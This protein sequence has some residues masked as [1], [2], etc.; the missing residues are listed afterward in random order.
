[1]KKAIARKNIILISI[2][3]IL[4]S[5]ILIFPGTASAGTMQWT[6]ID[7]PSNANNVIVSPSEINFLAVASSG[8]L[9]ATDVAHSKVYRSPDGGISWQDISTFLINAGA[10]L[11]AWNIE[12]SPDNPGLV[13]A[14][15]STGG[16][17]RNVFVSFDGGENWQNL[18]CP[19]VNNIS[20]MDISR[21]YGSYDIAVGT[22]NGAGNGKL[23]AF[24]LS[25][26]ANWQD[27]GITG[28]VISTMFSP[29]Y[30]G[31]NTLLA[32][33]ANA[34]GTFMNLGIRDVVAN[35]TSWGSWAPLEITTSGSGT[36]PNANQIK[37]ADI[38]MPS[39]FLGQTPS[40]RRI[41]VSINDGGATGN[42]GIFRI[43]NVIP[44]RIFPA[45]GN[46]MISSIS[47]YGNN[48]SGKLLAG[49][50][51]ADASLATVNIHVC[52]N[53]AQNCPLANCL[54]WHK[55][56]K[57]PTGGGNTGNGNAQV[58]WNVDGI[59]AYCGTSSADLIAGG[60]PNGYSISQALDE[61]AFSYSIDN[62]DTWNQISLIDTSINFLS[63]VVSSYNADTLYLTSINTNAGF[64]GFDSVWRGTGYPLFQKWERIMCP[65]VTS[66]DLI[67]R[68]DFSE[69]GQI[70]AGFRSTPVIY[71]SMDNGQTWRDVIPNVNVADFAAVNIDGNPNLFV[72]SD[73]FVRR[74]EFTGTAWHW[75]QDMSTTLFSG[76]SL[77]VTST[78]VIVVGDTGGGSAYALNFGPQFMQ[79]PILPVGGNV[80]TAVDIRIANYLLIYAA[81]DD[82]SSN[83]YSYIVNTSAGWIGMSAP[84]QQYYGLT[85]LG[86][87]YGVW[88]TGGNSGVS[89][90]LNPESRGAPF[91]E[92]SNLTSGLPAGISFTREPSALKASAGINLWAIDNNNYTANTG[93]L[94][95]FYDGLAAGPVVI[96]PPEYSENLLQPPT[97]VAPENDTLIPLDFDTGSTPPIEFK[98][99]HNTEANGYDLW[100]AADNNFTNTVLL[101]SV[102]PSN[103]M[104]PS[105][106]IPAKG[107]P[108]QPGETYYWK[109]RVNRVAGTYQRAEGQWSEIMSF[110]L[111]SKYIP[112]SPLQAPVLTTPEDNSVLTEDIINFIWEPVP[113][114]T[115]YLFVLSGNPEMTDIIYDINTEA[116]SFRYTSPLEKGK[117]YYWNVKVVEPYSSESSPVFSFSL[118]GDESVLTTTLNLPDIPVWIF[119][120]GGVVIILAILLPILFVR[121][122]GNKKKTG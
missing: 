100:I 65:L 99:R 21:N 13:A 92:W 63:D 54:V 114:A 19:A 81:T 14:V 18:N 37:T 60:W 71:S 89:R 109:V 116:A 42:T 73:V 26:P 78:G 62:A 91:I 117:T 16:L 112:E 69:P 28:D 38:D 22:R 20:T 83:I 93:R 40:S 108:L 10:T 51:K 35:T 32:V 24:K 76:H 44:Y 36:S 95:Q 121:L 104:S 33:T 102:R 23:W 119:F 120:V 122:A 11:P 52:L 43:D 58:Y 5:I 34:A 50:V 74:G 103:V 107:S 82:P 57:P 30:N 110:K 53:A 31:D 67:L 39:D 48:A 12:V 9:Y 84:Q 45:T 56:S 88:S 97:P 113:R 27:Q 77:T 70:Y 85:Q 47:Y 55:T 80:H 101:E 115:T 3:S 46:T 6:T 87:F 68:L 29:N 118:D 8:Y 2:L 72:L 105:W 111:E 41:Y 4:I 7:T 61:S 106:T 49:E 64:T 94:W 17:P 59:R 86:T 66:N 98:W 79:L 15:T 25:G 96:T 90:T 1:M 75:G